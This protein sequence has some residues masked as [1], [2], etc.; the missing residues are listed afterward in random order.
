MTEPKGRRSHL[1]EAVRL[2]SA[3]RPDVVCLQEVPLWGCRNLEDW[4]GMTAFWQSARRVWFPPGF[5]GWITRLD[6]GFFRSAVSGQANAI[7]LRPRLVPLE[8]ELDGDQP[9]PAR[10]SHLPG[11]PPRTDWSI[12]NLHASSGPGVRRSGPGRD[13]ARARLRRVARPGRRR[14]R[15]RRRLQP[16]PERSCPSCPAS[17]RPAR[18][19]TTSSSAAP[20]RARSRSGPKAGRTTASGRPLRSRPG[21]ASEVRAR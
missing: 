17:R 8:R 3:D 12:A 19:S 7:L 2:V 18:A 20:S 9:R 1:E 14:A 4:S 10:A 11:R 15:P 5:G 21:R 6:Q 16:A 13:P